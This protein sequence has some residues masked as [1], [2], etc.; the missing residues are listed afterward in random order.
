M[1]PYLQQDLNLQNILPSR[2]MKLKKVA[3]DNAS[4]SSFILF[5]VLSIGLIMK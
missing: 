3:G 4:F 1:D 5:L 2:H